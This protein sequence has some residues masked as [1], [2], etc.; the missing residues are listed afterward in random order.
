M[1]PTARYLFQEEKHALHDGPLPVQSLPEAI[2][3]TQVTDQAAQVELQLAAAGRSSLALKPK[4]SKGFRPT[5][6]PLLFIYMK[7]L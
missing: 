4:L 7:K 3:A 5:R 6:K 2:Q 1:L